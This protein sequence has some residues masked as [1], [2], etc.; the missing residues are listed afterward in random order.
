MKKLTLVIM[1]LLSSLTAEAAAPVG[2]RGR[3]SS[4]AGGTV[5][6]TAARAARTSG[7]RNSAQA[8]NSGKVV[9]RSATSQPK[10]TAVQQRGRSATTPVATQS[11]SR[12]RAAKTQSVINSGTKVTAA[13]QNTVVDEECL[14]KFSGCMDSFC[15]LDN[16][17]G[18]RCMCSNDNAKLDSILAE[19][20]KL[21]TQSYEMA[22]AGVEKINMGEDGDAVMAKTEEI[23]KSTIGD[24]TKSKRNLLDLSAL[25][26][27]GADFDADSDIFASTEDDISKLTGD[28][29]FRASANLCE[30]QISECTSDVSMIE[31]MYKQ[32]VRSDCAAYENSLK[33]QRTQSAQKL[34]AAQNAMRE[35]ALEQ[36]RSANKYDLGQCTAQFK[37]CMQTTAGCGEDFAGCVSPDYTAQ[38]LRNKKKTKQTQI[39]GALTTIEIAASTFDM[40][41]SKK[42]LC[43]SVTQNC[44]AVRD[45]VWDT[46]MREVAPELKSAELIAESNLRTSCTTKISECFHK[47][48]KD[49]IDP[50]DPDGSYDL[51][52]TRPETFRSLCK[53]EIDPCEAMDKNI[54]ESVYAVLA[55]MR[56]DSCTK[57]FKTCLQSEDRCGSDYTQCIGLDTDTIVRL[58]PAESLDSCRFEGN[59]REVKTEDEVYDELANIAQGIFLNIDNNMLS[60]CQKAVDTAMIKVCGDT[61]NCNNLVIDDAAGTR[62]FRYQVC[63][64]NN[65]N[66]N[67]PNWT[68]Q[69]F[70]S[71]DGVSETN[72]R[73]EPPKGW[74]GKLSGLVY[75]GEISYNPEQNQFTTYEEYIKAVEEASGG[76]LNS[77]EKK[78][79]QER[80]FGT[81]IKT[82]TNAVESAIKTIEADP[83]V[84]FCIKGRNFQGMRDKDGKITKLGSRTD[85]KGNI[86]DGEAR[87]PNLTASMRQVI[88]NSALLNARDNYMKKYDEEMERMM[89]DQV[90][91]A[92]R[93]DAAQ[94]RDTAAQTCVDWASSS[95]LPQTKTP[96][97]SNVGT[98]IAVGVLAAVAVVASI[99]TFGATGVAIGAAVMK[100]ANTTAV[101]A[102]I[103][104]GTVALGAAGTAVGM[105]V[106][107][108][109]VSNETPAVGESSVNQ[110]NY[111]E[112]VVTMFNWQTGV[113][114]KTTTTQNCKKTKKNYCKTWNDPVEKTT[115]IELL[116]NSEE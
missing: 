76:P 49:N 1:L 21:D 3:S 87:F 58:C 34:A 11:V 47:A 16:A 54:M 79:I 18:G 83:V 110:W 51:C 5:T 27:S 6:Q 20:Q 39:K 8:T 82:L 67:M 2:A 63:Q 24:N 75:W 101:T 37:Q 33:Q 109:P 35:A 60:Q 15:M 31:S 40:L 115:S 113:C 108:D 46:F 80:V 50:K 100:L 64:Y 116:N 7:V 95:T 92:K 48:C 62:S 52:L 32:R 90:T 30:A 44:V 19:I 111:K 53:V 98:W 25:N 57:D 56:V 106:N 10:Q 81:E 114:T 41:E 43:A 4:G 89:K 107:T 59:G 88:A 14:T 99:F 68:G 69:C 102:A 66:G 103:V 28:K 72:L 13:T 55:S 93:V 96:K 12:G 91:A 104:G 74:A 23:T 29:L 61:E 65:F 22:T 26:G 84:Q 70:D 9:S 78:I 77:E 36:Y 38:K 17:N 86:L 112:T 94:A 97:A 105:A 71:L 85:A 45:Q 42:P 73:Q